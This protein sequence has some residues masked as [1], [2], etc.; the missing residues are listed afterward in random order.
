[1]NCD[2][3]IKCLDHR[4]KKWD[5]KLGRFMDIPVHDWSSHGADSFEQFARGFNPAKILQ[6]VKQAQSMH[7]DDYDN[8]YVG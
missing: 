8:S 5:D 1:M 6:M 3:G 4:R 2:Q 7:N